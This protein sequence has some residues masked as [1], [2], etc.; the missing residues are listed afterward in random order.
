M[1]EGADVEFFAEFVKTVSWCVRRIPATV[2]CVTVLVACG[3][4]PTAPAT[5]GASHPSAAVAIDSRNRTS[6]VVPDRFGLVRTL[7]AAGRPVVDTASPF[8]MSLG[9]NGR[10]CSTCHVAEAGMTLTPDLVRQ[11][12]RKSGGTDPLFRTNDGS[13]SPLA[14]VSTVRARAVA[15]DLLLDR[16]VIR[17]GLGIP[18]GAE[19]ELV[20]VADPYGFASATQ[21]SLFRRP[22]PSTN[23]RFLS[24]VMW[25]GRETFRDSSQP[26]GFASIH[27]DLADQANAATLGHAQ[28]T[29]ALTADQREAI[30]A[31]ETGLYTAQVWD[32]R[33]GWLD[34]HDAHGGPEA[35]VNQ[36]FHF[37]IN[38]VLGNDPSG[39]PF[40]SVA[41]T[42]FASWA[43]EDGEEDFRD[44]GRRARAR[45]A[46]A[47]G[48]E[49]FNNKPFAIVGVAGLNDDLA[50]A[51]IPGTCTSCHDTPNAGDH[52]VPAPL[53]IGTDLPDPVGGLDVSGLP[54]YTLRNNATGETQQTTD[55]GRSLVT[56]KWK[57]VG[58]FKGPTLRGLAAR[59]P[60]FHNGSAATL[61]DV[62]RFYDTRFK[63]GLSPSE[64]AD[65]LAFLVAL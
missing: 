56:G 16:A 35:L 44:D 45:E 43:T 21:L 22:L 36:A 34:A 5:P 53:R 20:S 64:K 60:Y 46:I 26:T 2:A 12:F 17:V 48:E 29:D 39:Q 15:Y 65:L 27:F 52:S 58:R 55:P 51:S 25:D 28:A 18:E 19:F 3:G 41:M 61:E 24:T 10:G 50:I 8:F 33:A 62:I 13:T 38:D 49:L 23:L 63:I 30:V 42:L 47:R 14:D 1:R 59:A 11:R 4:E 32:S 6:V 9:T 7:N 54:V 40:T 37:G 31:F 57:D